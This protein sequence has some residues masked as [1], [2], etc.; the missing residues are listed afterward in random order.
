MSIRP[1]AVKN[2]VAIL[3]ALCGLF[4]GCRT[5]VLRNFH[6]V[7]FPGDCAEAS[8]NEV[9]DAIWRA[10]RKVGFEV[11]RI[12]PGVLWA[13]WQ[14]REHIAVVSITHADGLLSVRYHWSEN[15]LEENGRIHRSYNRWTERLVEQILREPIAPERGAVCRGIAPAPREP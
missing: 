7:P 10:G 14:V 9:D 5:E 4:T 6:A 3:A 2:A 8:I 13:T 1:A 15:L 12:E 11:D